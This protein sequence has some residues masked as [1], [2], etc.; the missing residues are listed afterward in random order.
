MSKKKAK[1]GHFLMEGRAWAE[2]AA[3]GWSY[4]PMKLL[5]PRGDGHAVL[6]LPGFMTGDTTTQPLRN[7]LSDMGYH[8]Y[9]WGQGINK[10]PSIELMLNMAALLDKI[11]LEHGK[12]SI[13]GWS[14]GGV[15]ARELARRFPDR[16]RQVITLGS[17]FAA[18]SREHVSDA[19][20]ALLEGLTG[21]SFEE[22]QAEFL[23]HG[24]TPPP[25]PCTA[26]Y[27][28]TDGVVHWSLCREAKPDKTHQN[29]EVYG[30][31]TG[32]GFN[33]S[34]V[35]LI[36]DRLSQPEDGWKKFDPQNAPWRVLYPAIS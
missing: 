11:Y 22:V 24:D 30:A 25:V 5:A 19:L 18:D 4:L 36:A 33:P 16:V 17:P 31:H 20:I 13:I 23:P 34:I 8:T 14:L 27:S 29:V 2:L 3:F 15:Y 28:K 12:V 7:F 6:V 21:K 10:G 1:L 26:A 35:W 9:G 32:L